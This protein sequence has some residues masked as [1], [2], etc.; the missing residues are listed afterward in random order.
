MLDR[1]WYSWVK[2]IS[3]PIAFASL[4]VPGTIENAIPKADSSQPFADMLST[5]RV[6]KATNA[7]E[8][9]VF[10]LTNV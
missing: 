2:S 1:N 7:I 6:I 8:C 5:V 10:E 9:T 3:N 4:F